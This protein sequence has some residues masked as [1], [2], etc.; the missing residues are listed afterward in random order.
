MKILIESLLRERRQLQN[1]MPRGRLNPA[2]APATDEHEPLNLD[3][4]RGSPV[5]KKKRVS[6]SQ[7]VGLTHQV[8]DSSL[9]QHPIVLEDKAQNSIKCVNFK[10]SLHQK[11]LMIWMMWM[12]L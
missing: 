11:T 1:L 2:P 12:Q 6:L 5:M 3:S 9:R 8:L 10:N 4:D 7:G